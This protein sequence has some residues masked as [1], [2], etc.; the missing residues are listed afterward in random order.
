MAH[1]LAERIRWPAPARARSPPTAEPAALRAR[2]SSQARG[3]DG[4][5]PQAHDRPQPS[6]LASRRPASRPPVV[7][8]P[9]SARRRA[10]SS[11]SEH[12]Q[13][14]LHPAARAG[15]V[16]DERRRRRCRP[17]RGRARRSAPPRRRR[18]RGSP[19]RCRAPRGRAAAAVT[20]GVRSVGVRPVPP[21][22]STTR[23]PRATAARERLADRRR[24][25]GRR[26]A[27]RP[28]TQRR[29]APRRSAGRSCPRT[30]RPPRGWT[31]TTTAAAAAPHGVIARASRRA[32]AG[33]LLDPH[34]GDHGALVDRLDH[35]DHGERRRRRPRSAPPSRRRCG[36]RCAPSPDLDRRRRRRRGRPSTAGIA[37]GWHERDQLGGPLGRHDAGDPGDRERVALGHAVAAQ[38]RD[39]L[40]RRQQHPAGGRAPR[41][42]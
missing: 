23:A 9:R 16:D 8:A 33:L 34:V 35:V 21:V 22:V 31:A 3:P 6:W 30:P 41:G 42:R 40:G 11:G 18:R 32:A 7:A 4:Q 38:Q 2:T 29:A 37:I 17:A 25:R 19:R 13:A 15:Q 36:R 14:V 1:Q 26:P 12:G 10:R 28:R 24:R 20:S 27:R 5:R 39:D